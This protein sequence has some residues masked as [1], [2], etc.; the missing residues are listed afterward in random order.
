MLPGT[1]RESSGNGRPL[2]PVAASYGTWKSPITAQTVA[3]ATLRLGGVALDGDD[4]YWIEGRPEDN[5][6]NVIVKRSP[7]AG[8]RT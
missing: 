2:E 4:I 6:H 8:S 3:A 1:D 7:T 5:G